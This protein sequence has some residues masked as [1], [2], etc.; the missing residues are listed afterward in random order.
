[1]RLRL[2]QE[3]VE[4]PSY[5]RKDG[6]LGK[7]RQIVVQFLADFNK[8]PVVLH[9][10]LL[11]PRRGPGFP[12]QVAGRERLV[13]QHL[14]HVRAIAPLF[15]RETIHCRDELFLKPEA[16]LHF[17]APIV[18][19]RAVFDKNIRFPPHERQA[20]LDNVLQWDILKACREGAMPES[21]LETYVEKTRHY[22]A[23]ADGRDGFARARTVYSYQAAL[24]A[25]VM[26]ATHLI[27]YERIA[28]VVGR[29]MDGPKV[30]A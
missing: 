9:C 18:P 27:V 19:R 21:K 26:H 6:E 14:D 8:G 30:A 11:R 24:A 3:E 22:L 29:L 28:L 15:V 23:T 17:H 7:Y 20:A 13:E 25:A 16:N 12:L 1:M 2:W 10:L 5:Q 4:H